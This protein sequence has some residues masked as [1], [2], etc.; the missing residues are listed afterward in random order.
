MFFIFKKKISINGWIKNCRF[1]KNI[2]FVDIND[3]SFIEDLQ[4]IC[5]D[6]EFICLKK[7]KNELNIGASVYIEG[8]LMPLK[9]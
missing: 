3:G 1:Q 5:K 9:N 7:I 6:N 2:F 8:I 4:V